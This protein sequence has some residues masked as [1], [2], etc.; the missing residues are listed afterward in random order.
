MPDKKPQALT[1]AGPHMTNIMLGDE[2]IARATLP[3][4]LPMGNDLSKPMEVAARIVSCYNALLRVPDPAE[5]MEAVKA[6][7]KG[8]YR[9]TRWDKDKVLVGEWVCIP[10]ED[11]DQVQSALARVRKAS[12]G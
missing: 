6:I 8:L 9:N 1:L 10:E 2:D 11:F 3:Q 4:T 7:G 12:G 5:F